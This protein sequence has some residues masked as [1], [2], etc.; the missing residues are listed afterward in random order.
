MFGLVTIALLIA[1]A[2][3]SAQE[4][5]SATLAKQLSDALSA[6]K[7]QAIAA[8]D[9]GSPDRFV[10]A[11]FY[12]GTQ[13]LVI[14]AQPTAVQLTKDRLSFRQYREIYLDLQSAVVPGSSWFFYDIKAD[15]VCAGPDQ[16]ADTLYDGSKPVAIFDGEWKKHGLSERDYEQAL[17]TTDQRYSALLGALLAEAQKP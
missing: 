14:S 7:L 6:K 9:P 15:G 8:Q 17:A 16:A 4:I 3:A 11:L 12:P 5:R 1:A 10:A 13:M 2:Q